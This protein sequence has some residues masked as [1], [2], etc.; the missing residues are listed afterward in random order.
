MRRGVSQ[1]FQVLLMYSFVA[2]NSVVT[3]NLDSAKCRSVPTVQQRRLT[4]CM[5]PRSRQGDGPRLFTAVGEQMHAVIQ[6]KGEPG[7][8]VRWRELVRDGV[9]KVSVVKG[10]MVCGE[11]VRRLQG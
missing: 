11:R 1:K 10:R 4:N 3:D 2:G 8:L 5:N 9:R 6:I 7:Q